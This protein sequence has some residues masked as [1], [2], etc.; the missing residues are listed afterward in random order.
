MFC[1]CTLRYHACEFIITYLMQFTSFS[2]RFDNV[3][4]YGKVKKFGP[5]ERL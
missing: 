4:F 5:I 2:G 1:V 3:K